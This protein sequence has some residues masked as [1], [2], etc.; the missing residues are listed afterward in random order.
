MLFVAGVYDCIHVNSLSTLECGGGGVG[1]GALERRCH[2]AVSNTA[3]TGCI[4]FSSELIE[5]LIERTESIEASCHVLCESSWCV[6]W[7]LLYKD[8][9]LLM[10]PPYM[11]AG[12]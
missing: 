4:P 6:S 11:G 8:F 3:Q 2:P 7:A 5:L 10:L 9:N 1:E 12:M